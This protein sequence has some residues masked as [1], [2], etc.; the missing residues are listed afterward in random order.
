VVIRRRSAEVE[1]EREDQF[2]E[3][4]RHCSEKN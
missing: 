4:R 1:I 2:A 3:Q